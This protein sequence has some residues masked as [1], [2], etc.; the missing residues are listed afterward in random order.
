MKKL[1][2]IVSLNFSANFLSEENKEG[3]TL[4]AAQ[5][6]II[7]FIPFDNVNRITKAVKGKILETLNRI[8]LFLPFIFEN[9]SVDASVLNNY[10]EELNF[11]IQVMDSEKLAYCG[12]D[13][14]KS[15]NKLLYLTP[16]NSSK[17]YL[18]QNRTISANPCGRGNVIATVD[19]VTNVPADIT[20]DNLLN[21]AGSNT[22]D[23]TALKIEIGIEQ[24]VIS[25]QKDLSELHKLLRS[26]INKR[27]SFKIKKNADDSLLK[28]FTEVLVTQSVLPQNVI[29][30]VSIPKSAIKS[31]ATNVEKFNELNHFVAHFPNTKTRLAIEISVNSFDNSDKLYM[32]NKSL[33]FTVT[34][35]PSLVNW[36]KVSCSVDNY[37]IYLHKQKSISMKTGNKVYELPV[38]PIFTYDSK[39]NKSKINIT[40]SIN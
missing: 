1:T 30:I 10:P 27:V 17:E 9:N 33:A 14:N 28:E 21:L 40:K 6:Q 4:E 5:S 26:F 16:K 37:F 23:I 31:N 25:L 32:D 34:N 2:Q 29:G 24:I 38:N 20:W 11:Y 8:Q 13:L 35:H 19:I 12:L 18:L 7:K 39:A 36:K 3:K 15:E 22:Q